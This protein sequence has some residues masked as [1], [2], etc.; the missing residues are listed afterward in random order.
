ML[1]FLLIWR[2]TGC[3][4]LSILMNYVWS[5]GAAVFAQ[6]LYFA[7]VFVYLLV[8]GIR[9]GRWIPFKGIRISN[10]L[11]TVL[12]TFLFMPLISFLNLFSMLFSTNFVSES[13]GEMAANPIW[14]NLLMVAV[15]PAVLEELVFRGVFYH[16][17]REKGVIVGALASAVVFGLLHMNFN[18]FFYAFVLGLIFCMLIEITGSIFTTIIAHFVVNGWNVLLMA[19]SGWLNQVVESAGETT[20]QE[21]TNS[22]IMAVLSVYGWL[23]VI[24]SSLAVCVMIW[25]AKRS[26]RIEHLKWCFRRHPFPPGV[27]HHFVTPAFIIAAVIAVGYMVL[28]ELRM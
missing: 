23:A 28:I 5:K 4:G 20:S 26:G 6:V 25:M 17:Y 2:L 16:A 1:L 21:L 10:I 14:L 3:F 8:K 24:C 9:P 27:R 19:I 15:I 13:A 7:P 18:Q 11:L 22:D 12:V